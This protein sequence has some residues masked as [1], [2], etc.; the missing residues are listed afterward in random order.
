MNRRTFLRCL[1]RYFRMMRGWADISQYL[2]CHHNNTPGGAE[3]LHK[4]RFDTPEGYRKNT[5]F[6]R[7]NSS[8]RRTICPPRM[9]T[10]RGIENFPRR[11]LCCM[12]GAY[13]LEFSIWSFPVCS[14][15]NGHFCI[16]TCNMFYFA[17]RCHRR[18]IELNRNI[19]SRIWADKRLCRR[20]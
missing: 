12:S 11:R 15:G 19:C 18:H 1:S 13:S 3:Y 5:S 10:E 9:Y 6:R 14:S 4:R 2:L 20:Q 8:F 16:R 17:N 7:S